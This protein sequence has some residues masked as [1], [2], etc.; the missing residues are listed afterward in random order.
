MVNLSEA[1]VM[2]TD[3]RTEINY[4]HLHLNHDH[5]GPTARVLNKRISGLNNGFYFI[6]VYFLSI[7]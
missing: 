1:K 6:I 2:S 4:L 5:Q 3:E 7:N